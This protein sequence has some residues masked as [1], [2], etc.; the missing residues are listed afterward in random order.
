MPDPVAIRVYRSPNAIYSPEE[1]RDA[2]K[3]SPLGTYDWS[4]L[5]SI[6]EN[7]VR[8]GDANAG[9]DISQMPPGL[10]TVAWSWGCENGHEWREAMS[11]VTANRNTWSY[12]SGAPRWK[13][14]AGKRGA[15]R[16]CVLEAYGLRYEKCGH[17]EPDLN[18]V[19]RPPTIKPGWCKECR[20]MPP[21]FELGTAVRV[22]HDPPTSR[23]EATL[24]SLLAKRLPLARPGEANCVVVSTTSLGANRV[25]PD[26]LIPARRV[27]IEYD[28]PG[29]GGEAHGPDSYDAEKDAALRA[30]GWEVI[31]V[32][33]RLPLVGPYDVSATGPTQKAASDV[34]AQ[35]SRILNERGR[36]NRVDS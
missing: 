23:E 8:A 7:W 15:C 16:Q 26:M 4:K 2:G 1:W 28:S 5:P 36:R 34:Y 24:R 33:V 18:H 31:R 20:E 10:S 32:R 29:M 12:R 9:V 35:Y 14:L 3:A 17:I 19:N 21:V 22:E 13:T 25:F 27:A 11:G 30:V 6:V